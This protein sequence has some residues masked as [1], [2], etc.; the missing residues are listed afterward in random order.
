MDS[1]KQ[2][3]LAGF[4]GKPKAGPAPPSRPSSAA[5]QTP[6][7]RNGVKPL[8]ASATQKSAPAPSSP[9]STSVLKAPSSL[10]KSSPVPNTDDRTKRAGSPLKQ[11]FTVEDAE[12]EDEL[13]PPPDIIPTTT[14]RGAK[15]LSTSDTQEEN[16][17]MEV[18]PESQSSEA[19]PSR[20]RKRKVVYAESN[21]GSSDDETLVPSTK[22]EL[23]CHCHQNL[24]ADQ[25]GRRPRKSLKEDSDSDDF[26]VADD[27]DDDVMCEYHT[28]DGTG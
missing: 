16:E 21:S 18:D 20:R 6:A 26:F 25:V 15:V 8:A 12:S 5:S 19:G 14:S 27:D 7:P 23:V 2:T 28:L 11:S 17:S 22:G 10:P 1:S 3:T 13:S 4:F 24:L 9:A